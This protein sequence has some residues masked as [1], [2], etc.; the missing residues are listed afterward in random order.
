MTGTI[1]VEGEANVFESFFF[2]DL[3]ESGKIKCLT[4]RTVW[5]PEGKEPEHG[6]N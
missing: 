2:A 4:E 5:G 1:K 6:V 3:D